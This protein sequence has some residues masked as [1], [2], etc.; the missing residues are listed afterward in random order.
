MT[1]APRVEKHMSESDHQP[2]LSLTPALQLHTLSPRDPAAMT[3]DDAAGA[4]TSA[5]Q[6]NDASGDCMTE[7]LVAN[8]IRAATDKAGQ[9]LDGDSARVNFSLRYLVQL[10]VFP[11]QRHSMPFHADIRDKCI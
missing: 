4:G 8:S 7:A 6:T 11:Y 1:L 10:S 5:A 2:L 3:P 9:L